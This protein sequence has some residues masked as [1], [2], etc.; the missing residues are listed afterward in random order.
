MST[1]VLFARLLVP[2]RRSRFPL[3]PFLRI[4]A[5]LQNHHHLALHV[6]PDR[7]ISALHD[8]AASISPPISPQT[9][10]SLP[11]Q[12]AVRASSPLLDA[13]YLLGC[14]FHAV[15]DPHSPYAA[16]EPSF[17]QRTRNGLEESLATATKL[18]E[19]LAATTLLVWWYFLKGRITEGQYH[20][21]GEYSRAYQLSQED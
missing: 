13:V 18:E 15:N 20:A 19:F 17:L 4:D 21:S 1:S 9:P 7:F 8:A 12:P 2:D 5:F 3:L 16:L 14:H 6:D 11:N 10:G